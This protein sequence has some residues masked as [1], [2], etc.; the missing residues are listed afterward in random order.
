S[1]TSSPSR[2]HPEMPR[3]ERIAASRRAVSAGRIRSEPPGRGAARRV[4]AVLAVALVLAGAST[5]LPAQAD[6][7]APPEAVPLLWQVRSSSATVYLYGSIHAAPPQAVPPPA[8]VRRA[9]TLSDALATEV[10]LGDDLTRRLSE[11]MA[12][13]SEL[14]PGRALHDYVDEHGWQRIRRWASSAG[15]PVDSI[16]RL[17]PWLVE[18][19]VAES[20]GLPDGFTAENGLDAYFAAK[21]TARG[22]PQ[23][24]L[25]TVEEQLDALAG[26]SFGEQARSLLLALDHAGDSGSIERLYE[27]WRSG[28]VSAIEAIILDHHG[29]ADDAAVY[30]RLFT[31]R[32]EAWI[33][34]LVE[35]LAGGKTTFVI[36]GAGHLV[37]HGNVIELLRD[38]GYAVTRITDPAQLPTPAR[39]R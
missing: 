35:Y 14:P 33:D 26:G 8:V 39:P 28:D 18:M 19:L 15:F 2:G 37:G 23:A 1:A 5:S 36:V 30:D 25:E 12:Q 9:F 13:R 10:A 24:G 20:A 32:N 27:A 21:A 11:A 22:I 34:S 38:R 17:Q 16:E 7:T 29:G 6:A 4:R 3:S 31:R